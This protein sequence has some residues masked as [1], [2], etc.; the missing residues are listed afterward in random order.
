MKKVLAMMLC[1]AM[2]LSLA[3]CSSKTNTSGSQTSAQTP[4]PVEDTTTS[5]DVAEPIQE[6]EGNIIVP[7]PDEYND[8]LVIRDAEEYDTEHSKTIIGVYEKKSVE[9]G[10][11]VHPGEDWGDGWLFDIVEVDQLGYERAMSTDPTGYEIF[12]VNA[13]GS[14]HYIKYHPTDV[15]I[16]RED[17]E[18]MYDE[19]VMAEWS[20]LNEWA[21]G[22]DQNIIDANDDL[23]PFDMYSYYEGFTY[24]GDHAY[25][26]YT[27]PDP[28]QTDSAILT[29][30]QP[31]GEG[32]GKVWCVERVAYSY[33]DDSEPYVMLIYPVAMG[34]EQTAEEYYAELQAQCDN[35]EYPEMLTI[36][37]AVEAFVNSEAWY[38]ETDMSNFEA[39]EAEG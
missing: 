35:G 22:I 25:V 12:A 8:L 39:V 28:E 3:A 27:N 31:T 10:E 18:T 2:V 29:L 33:S 37:G 5:T 1:M 34:I 21:Y 7:I 9:A 17:T 24:E 36:E 26:K 16:M 38:Y 20:M 11:I 15:R 4:P 23:A 6:D 30:S 13:D 14:K 32:E 19:E